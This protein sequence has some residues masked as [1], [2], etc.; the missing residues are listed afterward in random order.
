MFMSKEEVEDSAR[1]AGL[2]P[3]EYCLREISQWK[4]M[5]HEVSDDYCGLDDDEFDELVEREID[6]WRQEKENEG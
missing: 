6:S 3:R 2:T 5:L 1:R 4:D